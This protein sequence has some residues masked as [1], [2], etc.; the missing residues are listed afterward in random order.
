MEESAQALETA[1]AAFA[2][3]FPHKKGQ[4]YEGGKPFLARAGAEV[5]QLRRKVKGY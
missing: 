3:A 2:A 5:K 4:E 1:Q